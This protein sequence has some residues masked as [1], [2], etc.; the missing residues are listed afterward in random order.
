MAPVA[1]K[2]EPAQYAKFASRV[3]RRLSE[4]IVESGNPDDL[5]NLQA[6][7][8][9]VHALTG[10]TIDALRTQ[11]GYSW[12]DIGKGLGTSRQAAHERYH[13]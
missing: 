3:L 7:T 13:S 6:I 4:R 2:L 12:A 10:Q 9:E 11:Y 8:T 1:R 5:A